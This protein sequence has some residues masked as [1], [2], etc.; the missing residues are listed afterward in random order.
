[1]NSSALSLI[2]FLPSHVARTYR[3]VSTLGFRV[4][5]GLRVWVAV[6]TPRTQHVETAAFEN[7]AQVGA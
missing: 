1:M 4:S 3:V 7:I 6:T 2:G 5:G